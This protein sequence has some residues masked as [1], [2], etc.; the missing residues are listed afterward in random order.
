MLE[1]EQIL[2]ERDLDLERN[3]DQ[4]MAIRAGAW[5]L[6]ELQRWA[7]EKEQALEEVYESST[8]PYGPD[9]PLIKRHLLHCLEAH[10]G[11]LSS[12]G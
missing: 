4:L 7:A 1:V 11:D 8:I 5:S 2:V 12:P 9:E 3:R 10:Y 6:D